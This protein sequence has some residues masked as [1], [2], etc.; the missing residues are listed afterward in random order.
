MKKKPKI[1]AATAKRYA[2][3]IEYRANLF[4]KPRSI[5][6][7]TRAVV[8]DATALARL[9]KVDIPVEAADE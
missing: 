2:A 7:L 4:P 8:K 5:Q 9:R 6:E 1:P 3:L